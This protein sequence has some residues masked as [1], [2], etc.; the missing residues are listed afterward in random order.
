MLHFTTCVVPGKGWSDFHFSS[1]LNYSFWPLT[2]PPDNSFCSTSSYKT[3]PQTIG[4]LDYGCSDWR[5][6]SQRAADLYSSGTK[7]WAREDL[8]DIEQ[9]LGQSYTRKLFS[10]RRIDG[11]I[12]QISNPMFQ[13]QNPIWYVDMVFWSDFSLQSKFS[14]G[15]PMSSIRNIGNLWKHNQ[16]AQSKPTYALTSWIGATRQHGT[17]ENL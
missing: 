10:V 5:I 2:Y 16:M 15:N 3:M 9:Q 14:L 6:S 13:I 1:C 7:L 4:P 8:K 12:I 11:N 17:F